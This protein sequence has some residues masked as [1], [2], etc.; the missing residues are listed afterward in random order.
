MEPP[1]REGMQG[2]TER[3]MR[4]DGDRISVAELW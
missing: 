2:L 1:R 3:V 4:K